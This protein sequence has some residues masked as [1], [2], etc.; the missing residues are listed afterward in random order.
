M[1][2]IDLHQKLQPELNIQ[3]RENWLKNI[4]RPP[5]KTAKQ[6]DYKNIPDKSDYDTIPIGILENELDE[7]YL[8]LWKTSIPTYQVV[9][10]E[11]IGTM[12][13]E[14]YDP[15]A[16]VWLSRIGSGAV[17]IRQKK[18]S[19]ITDIGA[20]IKTAL[21]MDFPK[22][23]STCLKNACKTLG[24]RFGRDL[25]RKFEDVY[26]EI[27]T[28]EI[29]LGSIKDELDRSFINCNTHADLGSLWRNYP[30]IHENSK[31]K[32]LFEDYKYELELKILF[33]SKKEKMMPQTIESANRIIKNREKNSFTKLHQ[34]LTSL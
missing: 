10:N 22:L 27:Y 9:A 18:D 7:V 8:G 33:E 13:L 1:A 15:S 31:A 4:N 3:A 20:K 34:I 11:I 14:V 2:D 5:E 25:N 23:Y 17:T 21:Q 12:I 24:K 30:Q 29:E 16:K 6:A 19:D 32:K 28:N 26:E